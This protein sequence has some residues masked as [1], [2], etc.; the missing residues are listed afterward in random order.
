MTSDAVLLNR[1]AESHD[2]E[3]FA[4]IVKRHA[5]LVYGV[6]LR[7]TRNVQ[8]AEDVAQ[9]CF[10]DLAQ[11]S[12]AVKTS[13]TGWLHHAARYRSVSVIRSEASRRNRE[14]KVAAEFDEV[15]LA[16]EWRNLRD[17]VDEMIERLPEHLQA[18][19]IM[20]YLECMTQ[21][22]VAEATGV[23]QATI[24]RR[25]EESVE[26]LRELVG[27]PAS[28]PTTAS[29]A[30]MLTTA[31]VQS[32][33]PTLL[34][35]LGKLA[36]SGFGPSTSAVLTGGAKA[37]G[38]M[39]AALTAGGTVMK[40]AAG[41]VLVAA[42]AGGTVL[43]QKSHAKPP[44]NNL[45]VVTLGSAMS[46][47]NE[48]VRYLASIS[49]TNHTLPPLDP[50]FLK[51]DEAWFKWVQVNGEAH[52][53]RH[54][55]LFYE[56]M[57]KLDLSK[58]QM[59][60]LLPLVKNVRAMFGEF[61]DHQL[62]GHEKAMRADREFLPDDI[63]EDLIDKG[64]N[65]QKDAPG[66]FDKRAWDLMMS[67]VHGPAWW[68]DDKGNFDWKLKGGWDAKLTALMKQ[69]DALLTPEQMKTLAGAGTRTLFW[70]WDDRVPD[71]FVIFSASG[72][73]SW[74]AKRLGQDAAA[75]AK[76]QDEREKIIRLAVLRRNFHRHFRLTASPLHYL[77]GSRL[78]ADQLAQWE[79][80]IKSVLPLHITEMDRHLAGAGEYVKA[81]VKVVE[82]L[83]AGNTP[84]PELINA[85]KAAGAFAGWGYWD[86][87]DITPWKYPSQSA[88]FTAAMDDLGKQMEKVLNETQRIV[89]YD[90]ATCFIPWLTFTDPVNAGAPKKG[91]Y[92]LGNEDIARLRKSPPEQI[93]QATANLIEK[94]L[95]D[96]EGRAKQRA[97]YPLLAE[98]REGER[99]RLEMFFDRICKMTDADYELSRKRV[100]DEFAGKRSADYIAGYGLPNLSGPMPERDGYWPTID[101]KNKEVS[102]RWKEKLSFYNF[103][104][105]LQIVQIRL[106][107]TRQ[108]KPRPAADPEKLPDITAK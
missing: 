91:T 89:L 96:F 92:D 24:A 74:L 72:A 87:C 57:P 25:L 56:T 47:D 30:A 21:A 73:E 1:F 65:K 97:G 33:P 46:S 20:H 85:A 107:L 7:I 63:A 68:A 22:E 8:D 98:T 18:P 61:L 39:F 2:A 10:F 11:K 71:S 36:I 99:A 13:L 106:A 37:S 32:A 60:K 27:P 26:R 104:T 5:G 45:P 14:Q 105:V 64:P 58:G 81:Q 42:V 70:S 82:C 67:Q 16:P 94:S 78:S 38:G 12:R 66:N 93:E 40:I 54:R 29:L 75:D 9:M 44:A 23:S 31:G 51:W 41:V 48:E 86:R 102:R 59:E 34:A 35:H 43:V 6:A 90:A 52:Y 79:S 69:V 108:F 17:K 49:Y 80:S 3:A 95:K 4:E 76:I 19:L 100:A 77:K 103:P 15:I 55:Q 84:G 62:D 50:S 53:L 101:W 28:V 83:E 88:E